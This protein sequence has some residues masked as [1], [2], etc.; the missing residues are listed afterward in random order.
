[1]RHATDVRPGDARCE[2][3][4]E[5]SGFAFGP[6]RIDL[7][8]FLKQPCPAGISPGVV[9]DMVHEQSQPLR[10]RHQLVVAIGSCVQFGAV[11][12]TREFCVDKPSTV[13]HSDENQATDV[14]VKV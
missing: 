14:P 13:M 1:M 12:G 2:V 11:D 3:I 5:G 8:N 10:S 4:A 7:V 9:G 6:R